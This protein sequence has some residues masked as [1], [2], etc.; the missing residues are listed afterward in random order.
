[1]R[2]QLEDAREQWK[3]NQEQLN[4][5]DVLLQTYLNII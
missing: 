5:R 3:E 1:V 2:E 4:D